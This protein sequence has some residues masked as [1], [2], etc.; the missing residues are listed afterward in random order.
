MDAAR[1]VSRGTMT[2]RGQCVA[3]WAVA[4]WVSAVLTALACIAAVGPAEA[5]IVLLDNPP[6]YTNSSPANPFTSPPIT[7]FSVSSGADVL[8]F[9][10]FFRDPTTNLAVAPSTTVTWGTQ[11]LTLAA[12]AVSALPTLKREEAIYYL[13]DPTPARRA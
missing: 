5:G 8:V 7:P 10:V 9:E 4:R 1:L 3:R 12:N 6:G 13:Y 11:T 2:E